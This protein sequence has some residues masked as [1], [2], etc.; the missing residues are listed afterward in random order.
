MRAH[1]GL[2]TLKINGGIKLH[3]AFSSPKLRV[4]VTDEAASFIRD[5]KSV[6]SK[7]VKKTDQSLRP[8]DE[9]LIVDKKD[10]LLAIGRCLLTVEEMKSFHHGVAVK[11]R[12]S[13]KI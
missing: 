12:E 11:T 3:K 10:T 9:C 4:I 7:F 1:D 13:I 2:F 8:Y 6:Y 5:G